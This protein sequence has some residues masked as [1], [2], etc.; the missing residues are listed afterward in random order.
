MNQRNGCRK[1]LS[2]CGDNISI[3][4]RGSS[5]H[6]LKGFFPYVPPAYVFPP[7]GGCDSW[8]TAL[9]NCTNSLILPYLL[10]SPNLV[11]R[12]STGGISLS[13]CRACCQPIC[14]LVKLFNLYRKSKARV[15]RLV[16][17][18][19]SCYSSHSYPMLKKTAYRHH[20]LQAQHS[21]YLR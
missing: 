5:V 1:G 4:T 6:D 2:F 20:T 3:K 7:L 13:G 10:N 14:F 11:G 18:R 17:V 21:S 9:G 15:E 12:H 8:E 16:R 19:L